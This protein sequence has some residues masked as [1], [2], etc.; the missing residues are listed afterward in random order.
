MNL[1]T[2]QYEFDLVS[3]IIKNGINLDAVN[4]LEKLPADAFTNMRARAIYQAVHGLYKTSEIVNLTT[5]SD[6]IENKPELNNLFSC[7][8]ADLTDLIK[9][10]FCSPAQY[11]SYAKHLR[12]AMYVR[13]TIESLDEAKR[14]LTSDGN[15]SAVAEKVSK[16]VSGMTL[17]TDRKL[18]RSMK[19]IAKD[20]P[21]LLEARETP[22]VFTTGFPDMDAQMGSVNDDD[23]LIIA[24]RP[25]MGKTELAAAIGNYVSQSKSVYI[26][27]MEMSD[28]QV[29]ERLMA[30]N[31]N[32]SGTKI[33]NFFD[34]NDT[35]MAIVSA[36]LGET[37][38]RKIYIQD[39][40]NMTLSSVIADAKH[41]KRITGDLG[42][43]VIDYFGLIKTSGGNRTQELGE[44]SRSLKQLAKEIK[45]P[46]LLLCQLN[47]SLESRVDKR[48][49][50]SDLRE[51]GDLEQDADQI[52]FIYR[53]EVYNEDTSAKGIAEII[54]GKH[55]HKQTGRCL[56]T[57]NNGHFQS[58]AGNIADYDRQEKQSFSGG[59]N[60]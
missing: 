53:D 22:S 19:E 5:V 29:F 48:P 11:K 18:P 32:Y 52:M 26:C 41:V 49:I 50:M 12:K 9:N 30:I 34:N 16:I 59:M 10:S 36:S 8:L 2:T 47:R 39:T 42:L 20:I 38:T 25:G 28:T 6:T 27:S 31:G 3:S 15:L 54:W 58:F 57:F 40:P 46:V 24:A 4:I 44:I 37:A 14:L 60:Y 23:Y 21:R 13:Q 51:C 35:D 43:I 45:T 56:L 55:R 17:E 33:K 7:V 1:N